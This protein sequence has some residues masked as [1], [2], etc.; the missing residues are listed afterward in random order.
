[1]AFDILFKPVVRLFFYLT[2]NTFVNILERMIVIIRIASEYLSVYFSILLGSLMNF[3]PY[4]CSFLFITE[5]RGLMMVQTKM[6][7]KYL[8]SEF[9]N[10]L[11]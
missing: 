7:L 6:L 9:F 5:L 11:T 10:V 2:L 8:A 1:M 3:I 4:F